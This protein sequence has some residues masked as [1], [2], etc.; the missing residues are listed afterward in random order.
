MLKW[1]KIIFYKKEDLDLTFVNT[2]K[3]N[4]I[5]EVKKMFVTSVIKDTKESVK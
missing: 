2:A 3:R 1:K 5:Q 4:L